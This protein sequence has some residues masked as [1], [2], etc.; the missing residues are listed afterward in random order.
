MRFSLSD[1]EYALVLVAADR[2]RL[3]TGAFAAQ[4]TLAAARG[5]VRPEQVALRE[6]LATVMHAAGQVHRI[7]INL[8]QAVAALHCGEVTPRLALYADAAAR[9]VQRLDD[10]ADELRQRL[11]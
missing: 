2:E 8:N 10:L 9:A 6:S 1:E 3:A 7:G 5:Q 11:P 4:A